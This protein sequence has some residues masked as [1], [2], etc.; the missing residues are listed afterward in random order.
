MIRTGINTKGIKEAILMILRTKIIIK[1]SMLIQST[2]KI[3][4]FKRSVLL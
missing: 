4:D 2:Q 3:L 1:E